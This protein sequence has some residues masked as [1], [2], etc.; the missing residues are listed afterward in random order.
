MGNEINKRRQNE[1]E[2]VNIIEKSNQELSILEGIKSKYILE[3]LFDYIKDDFF[4]YKIFVHSKLYQEKLGINKIKYQII[5]LERFKINPIK[6][7]NYNNF[8]SDISLGQNIIKNSLY[9]VLSKYNIDNDI[10]KEY[11]IDFFKYKTN[12]ENDYFYIDIF[13]PLFEILSTSKKIFEKIFIIINMNDINKYFLKHHYISIFQNF[14]KLNINY[15]SLAISFYFEKEMNYLDD[16]NIDFSNLK[17]LELNVCYTGN[18]KSKAILLEKILFSN[19][20][21]KNSLQYLHL[22]CFGEIMDYR[23]F[24]KIN[25]FQS[26]TELNLERCKF[27]EIVILELPNL[28]KLNISCCNNIS[29]SE[30]TTLEIKKLLFY[31]FS[32]YKIGLSYRFP[33]LEECQCDIE[34]LGQIDVS[35][36]KKLEKLRINGKSDVILYDLQTKLSSL[37]SLNIISRDD[38]SKR[39]FNDKAIEI[40]E[41]K[42]SNIKE[43]S[44][45]MDNCFPNIK[46]YI[47]K[48]ENLAAFKFYINNN[49]HTLIN[50]EIYFPFFKYNCRLTFNYL[51]IFEFCTYKNQYD[52]FII[53]N[54][55]VK[56]LYENINQFTNLK[57]FKFIGVSE[58]IQR[59]FYIN[60][61]KNL[62]LLNIKEIIFDLKNKPISN[63]INI[64]TN[65][66]YTEKELKNLFPLINFFKFKKIEIKKL[67]DI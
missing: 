57:C 39:T 42:E 46:F 55:V 17:R 21:L 30:K 18:I 59:K 54:E 31:K 43:F 60:F 61:I 37:L 22:M 36:L 67:N 27:D 5:Y 47:N 58:N 7:L 28:I 44:L 10:F 16:L 20:N 64:K 51:R 8:N 14:K 1:K 49:I 3:Y 40:I 11:V 12:D 48:F 34:F 26:L 63:Y 52:Y 23:L 13:S 4:K 53:N 19:D 56:N 38:N 9:E 62:L 41:N 66:Y 29:L 32:F 25:N 50:P 65:Q 45:I 24:E 2:R 35:T 15:Y 33:K 6:Y